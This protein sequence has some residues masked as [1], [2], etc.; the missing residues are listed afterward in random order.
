MRRETKK[1]LLQEWSTGEE[2]EPARVRDKVIK[3][4]TL[5]KN[6]H[7]T[8]G[9]PTARVALNFSQIWASHSAV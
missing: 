9:R 7:L 3:R 5:D 6:E 8:G 4:S 1:L 2:E